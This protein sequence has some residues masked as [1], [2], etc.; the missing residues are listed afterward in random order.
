MKQLLAALLTLMVVGCERSG[1]TDSV[2]NQTTAINQSAGQFSEVSMYKMTVTSSADIAVSEA[3]IPPHDSLKNNAMLDSLKAYLSLTAGQYTLLKAAG[4]TLFATLGNIK[5]Q[6]AA[7]AI[8]PDSAFVLV[9]AGR[10]QFVTSVKA[11]LTADQLPTFER[12]LSL[13]WNRQPKIPHGPKGPFRP[14]SL[15]IRPDSLKHP[16]FPDSLKKPFMP[17]SLKR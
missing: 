10:D 13:Y 12:W 8:T 16:M 2:S 9:K 6:V 1:P 17:D 4:S 3:D 15:K 11:F 14:D 5:A 7:K